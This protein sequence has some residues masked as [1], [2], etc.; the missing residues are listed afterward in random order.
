VPNQN[1]DLHLKI[2]NYEET[3]KQLDI[4]YG[5]V[6]RQLLN[7]QSAITGLFPVVST[8]EVYGSVRES[9]YCAA[10]IWSVHQA[11]RCVLVVWKWAC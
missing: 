7:Y 10:A 8:D 6:K 11:Y 1:L 4:Y 2:S 3:V 5:I 9:V